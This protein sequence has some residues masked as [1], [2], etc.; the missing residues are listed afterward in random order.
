MNLIEL[1]LLYKS[2]NINIDSCININ[3][4]INC[5]YHSTI[6][7]NGLSYDAKLE[8]LMIFKDVVQWD[9]I[10]KHNIIHETIIKKFIKYY[11]RFSWMNIVRYQILSEPFIKE[12]INYVDI[13]WLVRCQ[14]LSDKLIE[15]FHEKFKFYNMHVRESDIRY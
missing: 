3:N 11:D 7:L 2:F 4:F 15:E 6:N 9:I 13:G 5:N 1:Y 10:L 8:F 12:Y 14:I